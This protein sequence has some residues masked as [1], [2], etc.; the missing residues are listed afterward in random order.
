MHS[1]QYNVLIIGAG[2][3]GALFDRPGSDLILTHAHAFTEHPGFNLTG[4]YDID[5]QKSQNAGNIWNCA[6]FRSIEEAFSKKID[7]V[8]IAVPDEYHYDILKRVLD[9]QARL[10]FTEKPLTRTE[11]EAEEIIKISRDRKI[12][13]MVNYSRRFVPE[14][15]KI[16]NEIEQGIYG[17]YL[18]GTGYYGKGIMHNGSHLIDLLRHL[19]GE[20]SAI[21]P[22]SSIQDFYP[23]DKSISAVLTFDNNKPFFLQYVDCRTY[24]IFELDILFE[25]KRIRIFDSGFRFEVYDVLKSTIFKDYKNIEKTAQIESSLN[26]AIYNAAEN[27]YKYLIEG[28]KIKCNIEDGYKT[29]LTSIHIKKSI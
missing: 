2:N 14:F 3:I 26:R 16:K 29:L 5:I 17:E 25:K 7:V 11:E 6:A 19:I 28:E 4:F 13:V 9:F 20:I 1:K 21:H 8:C 18:T 12:D 24:T 27:I 15:E 22:V 23:D 10:I